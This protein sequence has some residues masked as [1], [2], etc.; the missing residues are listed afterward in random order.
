MLVGFAV[1]FG[2]KNVLK[3]GVKGQK[4]MCFTQ[5]LKKTRVLLEQKY[6]CFHIGLKNTQV[7]TLCSKI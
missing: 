6:T 7:I 3:K 5:K 2:P 1:V 4:C